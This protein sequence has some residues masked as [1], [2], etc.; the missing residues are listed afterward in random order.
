MAEPSP[1]IRA[2]WPEAG[3]ADLEAAYALDRRTRSLHLR[4][5]MVS[6]LDGAIELGGRSGPLSSPA[7]QRVLST[8]R[9]LADVV[10]VG[11]RTAMIEGYGPLWPSAGTRSRRLA[12]GLSEAPSLALVSSSLALDLERPLF[13]Q[14]R[15]RPLILTTSRSPGS[16]RDSA[17]KVSD[18]IVAGD[19]SVDMRSAL[20]A[21]AER[22]LTKVLC[23]GGPSL[24]NTLVADDLLDELCLS[25][26]PM[27]AGPGNLNLAGAAARGS[28]PRMLRLAHVLS[29]G[30]TLFLRLVRA[31]EAQPAGE[32][33]RRRNAGF[34]GGPP[35]G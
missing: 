22:G 33:P 12:A 7:D 25:V 27:L 32:D 2:L 11:A 29:D 13:T 31:Q 30:A 6:A 18:V 17:A 20:A 5:N 3:A 23:E 10:L 26:A 35:T 1:P 24:L 4:A 16:T 15:V 28:W 8:L 21:L 9:S 14:A 34:A 19:A